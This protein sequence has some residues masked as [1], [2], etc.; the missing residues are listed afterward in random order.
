MFHIFL[1]VYFFKFL[2]LKRQKIFTKDYRRCNPYFSL[3]ATH[4]YRPKHV[5][6]FKMCAQIHT[7]NLPI[8]ILQSVIIVA[9]VVLILYFQNAR[10]LGKTHRL[11]PTC[12]FV[13][14]K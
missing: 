8:C 4:F 9:A 13:V 12:R 10:E 6:S 2:V 7:I 3:S 11:R 1:Y 5:I 14:S